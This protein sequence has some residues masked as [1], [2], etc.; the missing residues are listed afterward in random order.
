VRT[1]RYHPEARAEFLQEVEYLAAI[2]ARLAEHY[3]RA[4]HTAEEQAANTPESWPKYKHRTRRVIDRR[5]NFSM[6]YL[7]N[8]NEI[9]VVA[10]APTKRKPGYWRLRL[11]GA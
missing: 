9:Y 5:F 4:V 6:V 3:D 2:S 8:E 11:R 1:V 7:H 10:I